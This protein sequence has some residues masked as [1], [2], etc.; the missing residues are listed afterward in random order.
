MSTVNFYL[1]CKPDKKGLDKIMLRIICDGKHIKN[2]TNIKVNPAN[3]DKE[4][5]IV[6]NGDPQQNV[7]NAKLDILKTQMEEYLNHS[8]LKSFTIH[9]IKNKIK[10]LVNSY[11]QDDKVYI[12]QEPPKTGTSFTFI[13]L[14]AGAGGFSE[15]FLQA[16]YKDKFFD[17]VLAN[18]I[19]ENCELT[20]LVRYNHQ[21]GIN[22]KFLRQDISEPGFMA[23]LLE[24]IEGKKI[25]VVCGGPPCQSFS[26][27]GKRKK[28]DKKDDLFS[29]YL[30]VIKV[31][32]PKY[33][34]ME[35]VKGI[36]TKERG[37]IQD[38]IIKEIRS[39]IDV[40]KI[41]NLLKFTRMLK[42][43]QEEKD[44]LLESIAKRFGFEEKKHE[45]LTYAK[46]EYISGLENKFKNLTP[47]LIDYKTSK[48]D[49]RVAT[50]RHGLNLLQRNQQLEIIQRQ[51]IK[52]K[53]ISYIDNDQFVDSF[54]MFL[55][56]L[57]PVNIIQKIK[58]AFKS[59]ESPKK[60]EKI[61]NSFIRSL[62]I[63]ISPVEDC[64]EQL[65]HLCNT[66]I[67]VK[68]LNELVED[69]RLYN[70]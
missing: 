58:E 33:F 53:D 49:T 41:P 32:Q 5:Q 23:N 25:D 8:L 7:K 10:E 18:D 46:Q 19:N 61:I 68:E 15:G 70:I 55:D 65:N 22:M 44:L 2:T 38:L 64:I 20:H 40:N 31:L 24:K 12:V 54:N 67:Q 43:G 51:I 34:V 50:I 1:D 39:I 59:L 69:I 4:N 42:T 28:F 16:E 62:E 3:F 37:G 17:F 6:T 47:R 30:Q 63:Y 66:K 48:T 9:N 56:E 13:D 57:E 11:I 60:F 14:F 21:L 27:A 29:N 26:L 45:D 36:L 35:N 52:E